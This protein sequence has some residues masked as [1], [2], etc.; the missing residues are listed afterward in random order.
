MFSYFHMFVCMFYAQ[1]D[2]DLSD[3]EKSLLALP[4]LHIR[5]KV[6]LLRCVALLPFLQK[7]VLFH[8]LNSDHD[9]KSANLLPSV[10][11][12]SRCL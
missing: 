8:L 4:I 9:A 2:A 11:I 7:S 10:S 12:A 6:S 3:E 1:L 5:S